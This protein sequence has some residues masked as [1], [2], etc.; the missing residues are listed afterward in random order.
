MVVGGGFETGPVVAEI[1]SVCSIQGD[2]SRKALQEFGKV[3][4]K[5]GFAGEAA[6]DRVGI[7]GGI[8][9]LVGIDD[10][11]T[12]IE[13]LAERFGELKVRAFQARRIGDAAYGIGFSQKSAR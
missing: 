4:V 13:L 3:L 1:V 8:V 7:I 11:K 2:V 9:N 5:V 12:D 10:F 6:V